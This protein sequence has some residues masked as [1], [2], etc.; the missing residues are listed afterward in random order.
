MNK[1]VLGL[2]LG[3]VFGA[4]DGTYLVVYTGSAAAT[5]LD[6]NRIHDQGNY[7]GSS[8]RLLRSQSALVAP[9][10]LFGLGMG[11]LLAFFVAHMQG[12]YYFEIMLPG[13]VVGLIV[14]YATQKYGGSGGGV[15]SASRS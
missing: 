12:G 7:C 10:Y 13:G 3:G 8:D 15:A 2:I 4:F 5:A 1:V 14:G 11:L 6:C 9:R